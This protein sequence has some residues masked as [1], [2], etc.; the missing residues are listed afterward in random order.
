MKQPQTMQN[1]SRQASPPG[2]QPCPPSLS[3]ALLPCGNLSHSDQQRSIVHA[4]ALT[5]ILLRWLLRLLAV[6]D[7]DKDAEILSLRHQIVFLERQLGTTRPRFF[8][9]DRALL[10]RLSS[11]NTSCWLPC[12]TGSRGT[13]LAGSGC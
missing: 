4:A 11:L 10:A 13:C 6:S 7:R 3:V 1:P 2:P 9:R 5:T 8:P 12:C